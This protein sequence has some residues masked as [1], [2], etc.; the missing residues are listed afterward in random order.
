[1]LFVTRGSAEMIFRPTY[2]CTSRVEHFVSGVLKLDPQEV[3]SRME[4]FAIQGLTG[5][6]HLFL[7]DI[8]LKVLPGAAEIHRKRFSDLRSGTRDLIRKS[9][10]ARIESFLCLYL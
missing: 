3:A 2:F 8:I 1:M 4:G 6:S 9:L 5:E 10:S 7:G